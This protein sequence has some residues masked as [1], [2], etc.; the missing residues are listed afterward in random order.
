MFQN[1]VQHMPIVSNPLLRQ[2]ITLTE[3]LITICNVKRARY[4]INRAPI[5]GSKKAHY[6]RRFLNLEADDGQK[7]I[8]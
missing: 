8:N 1:E 7:S 2:Y 5:R 6:R 4:I 3:F